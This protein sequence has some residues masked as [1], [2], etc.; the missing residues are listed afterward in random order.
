VQIDNQ[1]AGIALNTPFSMQAMTGTEG[2]VV[3]KLDSTQEEQG[4]DFE[5]KH[6]SFPHCFAQGDAVIGGTVKVELEGL[7]PNSPIH[8]NLGPRTV[9]TGETNSTGGGTIDFPIP[10][11]ASPGLSLITVGVEDTALTADCLVN[12]TGGLPPGNVTN[13]MWIN[14]FDFLPGDP[15]IT[16]SSN[17]ISSGIGGGLTGLVIESSTTGETASGGGNK[18]VHRALEVP[19]GSIIKEVRVCY[20]STSN[21]TYISQIRLSQV[22]DPPSSATVLLDDG[23][24]LVNPGPICVN[25]NE[26]SVD[27]S[28]GPTLLDLRL[29]FGNTAD[30]IV[31][32]GV[33]LILAPRS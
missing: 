20:E 10:A 31:L 28:Q 30:K 7:I 23:T 29:N 3:D 26:T 9:F 16:T 14:H 24:D 33:G 17:A 25:S 18:V 1:L 19:P 12:V 4:A 6:P 13:I 22:R 8:G 21:S 27:P 2:N 15:S 5:L 11:D 32:R